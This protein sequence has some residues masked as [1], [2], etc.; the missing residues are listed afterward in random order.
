[1]ILE[2]HNKPV[3]VM[4]DYGKYANLEKILDYAEDYIL[5][6]IALERKKNARPQ[7]Y[8]DIEKW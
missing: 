6:M 2:K 8:V 5:R 7:D 4:L 1:M 3:I